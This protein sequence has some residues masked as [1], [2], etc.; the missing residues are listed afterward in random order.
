MYDAVLC[1]IFCKSKTVLKI[2]LIAKKT[3]HSQLMGHEKQ[4]MGHMLT[5]ALEQKVKNIKAL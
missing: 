5:T 2:K 1:V 3:Q 4:G